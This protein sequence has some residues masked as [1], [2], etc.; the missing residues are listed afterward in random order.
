MGPTPI[1]LYLEQGKIERRRSPSSTGTAEAPPIPELERGKSDGSTFSYNP[2]EVVKKTP[3]HFPDFPEAKCRDCKKV[4]QLDEHGYCPKCPKCST[5]RYL[6]QWK[7]GYETKEL[8]VCR[9]TL[10]RKR[11]R[12]TFSKKY[13][14]A[15]FCSMCKKA[16]LINGPYFKEEC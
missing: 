14:D 13:I 10:K 11:R 2:V 16:G 9:A 6:S 3:D 12:D 1:R 5:K 7:G 8:I 15:Y 4:R